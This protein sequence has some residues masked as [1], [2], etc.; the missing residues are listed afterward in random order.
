MTR[1]RI[2]IT[3]S[4]ENGR[5]TLDLNYI[6]AVEA[7]G[8]LPVIAPVLESAAAA[9]AF[10]ALLDGLI[11][12]GGPGISRGLIGALPKDLPAVDQA[13]DRS[14][15][16]IYQ[17]MAERP[18][19]GICYGMQFANAMAGG[20]IYGDAQH[21]RGASAHS[22]ERGARDHEIQIEP[23]SRL[24]LIL[25]V[26]RMRTNTRHIQAVARLG[27]GMRVAARSA[28]GV[29]EAIESDDGRVIAVQFHPERMRDRGLPLFEDLVRRA[30]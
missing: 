5:Q 18:F 13:R 23:G 17:A 22:S 26:E 15:E 14:D 16:L 8:G 1:P 30:I 28:D 12:T 2:G 27:A 7:A 3:T 9:R 25:G 11:I 10:A 29:I 6:R 24:A 19:L 4:L 21:Q 20:A